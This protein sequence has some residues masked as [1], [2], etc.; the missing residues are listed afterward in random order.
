M[1]V[2]SVSA[3]NSGVSSGTVGRNMTHPLTDPGDPLLFSGYHKAP[4]FTMRTCLPL[5]LCAY[6]VNPSPA[7]E[8]RAG[9]AKADITP[10]TGYP[11]WG[12]GGRHDAACTGVRDPLHA[13]A[14]V[15]EV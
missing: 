10:P 12:Y 14:L 9:A 13:R 15:L 6:L 8:L 4:C 3:S 5:L 11:M 1:P 7:A 2:C